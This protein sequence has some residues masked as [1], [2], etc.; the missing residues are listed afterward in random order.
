MDETLNEQ[1]LEENMSTEHNSEA[2]EQES[3]TDSIA[4]LQEIREALEAEKQARINAEKARKAAEDSLVNTKKELKKTERSKL[5]EAEQLQEQIKEF[6]QEKVQFRIEANR[7]LAKGIFAGIGVTE[8]DLNDDDLGL[9]VSDNKDDTVAR[10][11]WLKEFVT[12]RETLAAKAERE[13][14]LKET[15]PPPGGSGGSEEDAFITA[16][17]NA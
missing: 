15:P 2:T 1:T 4:E 14:V 7:E 16:L 5:S 12:K 3:N 6:E 17:R 8:K 10:C 9:F 11:N 13:K